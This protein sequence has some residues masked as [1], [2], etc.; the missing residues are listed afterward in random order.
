MDTEGTRVITGT[1][2][3]ILDAAVILLAQKGTETTISEIAAS[4]GVKDSI[5]YHYFKNKRDLLFYAVGELLK[6][7]MADLEYQLQGIREPVSRLSKL[8]WF[9]LFYHE[10]HPQ[11]AR[12]TIF[13][14][15]ADSA[16]FQHE[17]SA[18]FIQWLRI[19]NSIIEDGVSEGTFSKEISIPVANAIILGLLD[20]ENIQVFSGRR[21]GCFQTDFDD[22]LD[23]VLPMMV[24]DEKGNRKKRGKEASILDAAEKH[25]AEGGYL[26]T[27]TMEIARSAEVAE[28]TLYEYFKNKEDILF[29][30]LRH[31]FNEH[32]QSMDEF[33]I[34]RT[35]A[36]KLERFVREHFFF[37]LKH[38]AFLKTFI[39]AGVYNERFYQSRAYDDFL[40]YLE[41]IDRILEEGKK[42]GNFR[43]DI[44]NRVFKNLF[45]GGFS[46]MMLRWFH[47]RPG[48]YYGMAYVIDAAASMLLKAIAQPAEE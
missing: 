35:P 43:P 39:S 6:K 46:H 28:A 17:A 22:I 41:I 40:R 30:T 48:R 38:P 3:Q 7:M 44:S 31:R 23:L 13:E 8:I 16:F 2:K 45:F 18:P 19:L 11:Y 42:D 26:K 5:I 29:S 27:T 15:R 21:E 33:F 34:M 25:F 1:K 24:P 37:Y 12:F 4:A 14:C 47:S 32:L 20:M 9:Q 10:D 36:E